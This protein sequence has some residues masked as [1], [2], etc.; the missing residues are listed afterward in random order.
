MSQSRKYWRLSF[1]GT[2]THFLVCRY[3]C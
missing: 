2:D 3:K 1:V